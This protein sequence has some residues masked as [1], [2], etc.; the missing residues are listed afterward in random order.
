MLRGE[1]AVGQSCL[2][3]VPLLNSSWLLEKAVSYRFAHAGH[4]HEGF[5]EVILNLNQG[6]P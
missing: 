2:D 3:P 5:D 4:V 6:F 1:L